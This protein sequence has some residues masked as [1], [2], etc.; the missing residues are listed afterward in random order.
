MAGPEPWRVGVLFSSTGVTSVIESTQLAATLLAIQE[1]NDAGGVLGR[2]LAP[3]AYDPGSQSDRFHRL[4]ER[5]LLDDGVA[6][7]FG[8]YTSSSRKAVLPAL[9]RRNGLLLYPTLYEGFEFSPNVIYTGAAPNQNSAQLAAFLLEAYGSRFYLVGSD[10]VFPR[11]SNRIFKELVEERGGAIVAE[12]YVA[13]D[14]GPAD[15]D[16][17]I[18]D[19]RA[20]APDVIFSTVVGRG[21]ALLYRAYAEAGLDP[22]RLPIASLTTSEAEAALMGPQIAA[23]HITAAPY[24]QSCGGEAN[25]RFVAAWRKRHGPQAATNL[26]AEAAYFQVFL[27]AEALA[28]TG[29]LDADHLRDALLG[30]EFEAPQGRVA[31]DPDNQHTYLW[32]RIG[33]ARP[34]GQFEIL[35]GAKAPVK[36]D[37]YLI[38][39]AGGWTAAL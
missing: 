17:I 28:R 19:V 30:A 35:R 6:V 36:P 9:E 10:Y 31:I 20:R 7:I 15:F 34:D 21:T 37:P 8:C 24:F 18:R 32:P 23:G 27:L 1:I 39:F 2:P 16:A 4:A 5:L 14:A 22:E 11:E 33:R 12:R 3:V 29:R 26:C 38:G 13:L 25:R